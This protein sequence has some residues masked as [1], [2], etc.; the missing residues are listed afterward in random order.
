MIPQDD[1]RLQDIGARLVCLSVPSEIRPALE[2]RIGRAAAAA[3]APISSVVEPD[4]SASASPVHTE[5]GAACEEL[6]ELEGRLLAILH[7]RSWYSYGLADVQ[8]DL[9]CTREQLL[10][11][12][13][14]LGAAVQDPV[15]VFSFNS[16]EY[17]GLESRRVDYEEDKANGVNRVERMIQDG[18]YATQ[19][20][21][22]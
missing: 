4:A 8:Q 11:V 17:I 12:A 15:N 14:S 21:V 7:D 2:R 1:P 16:V 19:S 3:A 13:Q 5:H 10:A 18:D 20:N 22:T 6:S 9:Q